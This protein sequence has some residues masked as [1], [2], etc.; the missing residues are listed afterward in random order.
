MLFRL[1]TASMILYTGIVSICLS[2]RT[3]FPTYLKMHELVVTSAEYSEAR[4]N[5]I[6]DLPYQ[7]VRNVGTIFADNSYFHDSI[8]ITAG[9]SNDENHRLT[10]Y[11]SFNDYAIQSSDIDCELVFSRRMR[12]V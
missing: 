7:L 3:Q 2:H 10:V 6:Y 12:H 9:C 5:C 4:R 8:V 11:R 1:V